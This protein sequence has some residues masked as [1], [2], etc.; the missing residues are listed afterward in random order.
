MMELSMIII[1]KKST[2]KQ[3][4]IVNHTLQPSLSRSYPITYQWYASNEQI[5]IL[6]G[7]ENQIKPSLCAQLE[8]NELW[9]ILER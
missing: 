3:C 6:I 1:G 8:E 5:L 7:L 9:R 2:L 4:M